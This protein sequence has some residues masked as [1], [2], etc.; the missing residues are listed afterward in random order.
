MTERVAKKHN[1]S[2][3]FVDSLKDVFESCFTKPRNF[4]SLL[5][6]YQMVVMH[7]FEEA[8][9]DQHMFLTFVC[10]L[11]IQVYCYSLYI[12]KPPRFVPF[13]RPLFKNMYVTLR[14]CLRQW[15][16]PI[17]IVWMILE[18]M[19]LATPITK[20]TIRNTLRTCIKHSNYIYR[21]YV[22]PIR[23]DG[24]HW[25]WGEILIDNILKEGR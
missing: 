13:L 15:R 18:R 5:A 9:D 25:V 21:R 4:V 10:A 19:E 14:L 20:D 8:N 17:D 16:I 12:D 23:R 2:C 24:G 3:T 11:N 1:A 6:K 7:M 22:E